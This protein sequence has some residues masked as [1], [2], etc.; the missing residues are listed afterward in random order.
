MANKNYKAG[1]GI[2]L[3]IMI[4][5]AVLIII[6]NVSAYKK[7]CLTRG[8]SVPSSTNPRYTCDHDVCELCVTTKN[9]PT[10]PGYCKDEQGC[11][12]ISG[13]SDVDTL[14]PLSFNINSPAENRVYS[15][16]VVQFNISTNR[17]ATFYY[18]DNINNPDV[19]KKITRVLT[20]FSGGISL[21]E[22]LNDITIKGIDSK[23]NEVTI[24]KV[25]TIDSKAPKITKSLPSKGLSNGKFQVWF[26]EQNPTSI[27]L[28]YGNTAK[29]MRNLNVPLTQCTY[30]KGKY[31]C[32]VNVALGDYN[33][34]Q[35]TYSF[36]VT[37]IAGSTYNGK[38]YMLNVDTQAPVITN[39]NLYSVL[40][41]YLNLNLSINETNFAKIL[42]KDRND[43]E[44]K[45]KTVCS[46]LKN[47]MC[48]KKLSFKSGEYSMDLKVVDKAG[49]E[50]M[51]S[52]PTFTI[53]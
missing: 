53:Q 11:Q 25:F 6:G 27:V 21:K 30:N 44:A 23:A 9:Y 39:S 43:A 4:L 7:V 52:I 51:R 16:R 20:S 34:Q 45:W 3:S 28:D 8:Q 15:S 2:I 1:K 37:D 22:G 47:G 40:G 17:E 35:I 19:W 41:K 18:T 46:S 10:A 36:K 13:Q 26:T 49:N 12:D 48:I 24:R 33:G 5:L 32:S 42:I 29:G 38:Q 31:N 50:L 14:P